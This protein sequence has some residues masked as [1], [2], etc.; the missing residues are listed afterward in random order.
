MS[1]VGSIISPSPMP[2]SS[3]PFRDYAKAVSA[4]LSRGD[5]TE[6]THRPALIALL[7]TAFPGVTAT[8]EPRRRTDCGAPDCIVSS[9]QVTI[10]YIETKDVETDLTKTERTD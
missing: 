4:N 6:H 3:K 7:E 5:A 8:N 2:D 10:G 1:A 9:G